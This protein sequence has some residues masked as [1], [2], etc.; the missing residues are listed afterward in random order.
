LKEA[1]D[2]FVDFIS[3]KWLTEENNPKMADKGKMVK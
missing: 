1:E 2:S 3:Q